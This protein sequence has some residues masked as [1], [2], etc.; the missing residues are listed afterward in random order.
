M[1]NILQ[2]KLFSVKE[3]KMKDIFYLSKKNII[4]GEINESMS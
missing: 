1:K 2:L 3:V 4:R